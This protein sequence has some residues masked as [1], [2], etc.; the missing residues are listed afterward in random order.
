MDGDDDLDLLTELLAENEA[1][2]EQQASQEAEDN[3][4][5][6]FDND[7]DDEEYREGLEGEGGEREEEDGAVALFGDVDGIEEEEEVETQPSGGKAPDNLNKSQEDLQEEL[8]RMQE[9]MQRL[10][11]QL[12]ASQKSSTATSTPN[13]IPG[14]K[15]PSKANTPSQGPPKQS[16][17]KPVRPTQKTKPQAE[18]KPSSAPDRGDSTKLQESSDFT[19]QLNNADLFKRKGQRTAHQVQPSTTGAATDA[20]GPLV[21]IKTHSSFQPI[22]SSSRTNSTVRSSLPS[23][24]NAAA[25]LSA[26]RQANPLPSLPKDVAIEK[27][28]G[29]RLRRPRVSSTEMDRK[30]ADRKLIR[31]SQLPGRLARE[32]LDECDWVTFAVL[33]N[34]ATP[35]SNSSGK[36]FSIWKLSDLHDLEVYVSLFLFGE[37]HKEHWKTEPGTV[38]GIL[39][40]NPMKAKDGY[41]GVSLSVDHHQKVL[42]MGEA[43]DYGTCK[44]AKKNGDPCSQIVNLYECQYCQYHVKAQYKR[45]SAQRAELQSSFSGKATGKAKGKGNSLKERLCQT[46]FHYGGMSSPACAAALSAS[47][48]KKP[49]QT[50]LGNLFVKGSDQLASQAKRLAMKSNEVSG[51]SD[52]FKDLLSMPTPGALQLKRHL[53]KPPGSKG[54]AGA[55]VQ[56][57]SAS[58]LLKQQKQQQKQ[59]LENRRRRAEEIQQRV[60]QNTGRAGVPGASPPSRGTLLSPKSASEVPKVTQSPTAPHT[61]T[62]GRGFNEGDDILFFDHTP[63]PPP[64][65]HSLSAA[66]L[67]ALK[68]LRVKGAGLAKEDPN[69]VKRKRSNST[70]ITTRV[71]KNLSSSD[72]EQPG[73]KE[74]EPAQKKRREKMDYVQSEEFKKILNAKSRHGAELQ[75]AE[76]QQQ[77]SYFDP[78]VKKEA[79]EDKM[80]N[81]REQKCRAV[82]CKKCKYTYFKPADRC[83]EEKHELLWH[84]A[85]KRFFKCPCGQRAIALDR[86]PHKHCSNCGLFKW[87]RDGMLKEKSGPKIAGELLQPRGDEQ[88]KFLNSMQ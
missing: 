31:L 19:A 34:K 84:D 15:A 57:I 17:S 23:Q 69:A 76:Y 60:L 56:S 22:A 80:R 51:C 85:T 42:L 48:P 44:A 49:T 27:Y 13:S 36:T 73:A 53:T 58:D 54:S 65:P 24:S 71:Q 10:Q 20:R 81:I 28:S 7:D 26:V 47:G 35:Q 37:V 74:E 87:E 78:L 55:G 64:T 14:T 82:S 33:V 12:E 45:M 18:G 62:L 59:L 16:S 88:P 21:E 30:M 61:P 4:D 25:A 52:D 5:D 83:V 68:K 9:Q 63:P 38:M 2:E 67:A 72:G 29:L 39:N 41:D 43:Q 3:L 8:R 86:L 11:Q 50:T 40:P 77:E 66:K 79:M 1:G 32:K 46:G 6:L 75:A 70:D